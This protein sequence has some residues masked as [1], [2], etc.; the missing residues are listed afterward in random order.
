[1][2]AVFAH[3]WLEVFDAM[4]HNKLTEQRL[5]EIMAKNKKIADLVFKLDEQ[6]LQKGGP[7]AMKMAPAE[8]EPSRYRRG[9]AEQLVSRPVGRAHRVLSSLCGSAISCLLPAFTEL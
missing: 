7:K 1:M 8:A 9:V 6:M 4:E 5:R 2:I 3:Y